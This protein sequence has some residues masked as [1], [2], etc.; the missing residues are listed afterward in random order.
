MSS[1]RRERGNVAKSKQKILRNWKQA[2]PKVGV[3]GVYGHKRK[4]KTGM[5]WWF[6]ET[7]HNEGRPVAAYLFPSK[8]RKLLPNWVK[9]AGNIQQVKKLRGYMIVADE[10]AIHANAREHQSD[11]NKEIYKLMAIAAQ[12]DQLLILICQHT[13][14]LDVGLVMDPDIIIFKKPTMLHIR[15]ARPELRLEVQEA[16]DRFEKAR[17]DERSWAFVVDYHNGHKGFLRTGLP[18]FWSEKLSKVYSLFEVEA[19]TASSKKAQKLRK[20]N[21]K[22]EKK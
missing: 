21:K 7:E 5:S 2:L 11:G 12:C 8:G 22:G 6:A 15:F 9:H 16:F 1:Q 17:G 4:G 3:V 14:Q 10:M 19:L 20:G 13:R 18:S